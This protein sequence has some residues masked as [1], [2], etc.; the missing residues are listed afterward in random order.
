MKS[1]DLRDYRARLVTQ[2]DH[3]DHEGIFD[4]GLKMATA[5]MHVKSEL[6]RHKRAKTLTPDTAGDLLDDLRHLIAG[7]L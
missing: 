1:N 5:I 7:V 6:T 3:D 4:D 2:L